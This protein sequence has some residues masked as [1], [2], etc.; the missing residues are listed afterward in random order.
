MTLVLASMLIG[1]V[2]G[3][4]LVRLLGPALPTNFTSRAL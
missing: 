4:L 2:F 1:L 3:E